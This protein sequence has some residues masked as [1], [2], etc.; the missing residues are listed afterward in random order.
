MRA[1]GE[2]TDRNLNSIRKCDRSAHPL[3]LRDWNQ[4]LRTEFHDSKVAE[5][6]IGRATDTAPVQA[7][8]TVNERQIL[9]QGKHIGGSARRVLASSQTTFSQ[10]TRHLMVQGNKDGLQMQA[11]GLSELPDARCADYWVRKAMHLEEAGNQKEAEGLLLE[12]L[13][14]DVQPVTQ[15]ARALH[16][17]Q[18]RLE[19]ENEALAGMRNEGML[20]H[21]RKSL[22]PSGISGQAVRVPSRLAKTPGSA[23]RNGTAPP[24]TSFKGILKRLEFSVAKSTTTKQ[25]HFPDDGM[26]TAVKST[27]LVG[28]RV[29]FGGTDEM[30]I[31][32]DRGTADQSSNFLPLPPRRRSIH[33]AEQPGVIEED[34]QE[35]SQGGDSDEDLEASGSTGTVNS[36]NAGSTP[37][38]RRLSAL[39]AK[40]RYEDDTDKD[41]TDKDEFA[42]DSGDNSDG[43]GNETEHQNEKFD[44]RECIRQL[45]ELNVNE[46]V[47]DVVNDVAEGE[48][49]FRMISNTNRMVKTLAQL[50]RR[51]LE[52]LNAAKAAEAAENEEKERRMESTFKRS[53]KSERAKGSSPP[54]T[55][56]TA[57]SSL[58]PMSI[59]GVMRDQQS[60]IPLVTPNTVTTQRGSRD[61]S[62]DSVHLVAADLSRSFDTP[63]SNEFSFSFTFAPS[64]RIEHSSARRG[65]S[66]SPSSDRDSATATAAKG[67]ASGEDTPDMLI[68]KRVE[69]SVTKSG[70]GSA[71]RLLYEKSSI[72]SSHRKQTK[73]TKHT[74]DNKEGAQ[75]GPGGVVV[76]SPSK[77]SPRLQRDLGVDKVATPVR[78]SPRLMK[79]LKKGDVA[80]VLE[81]TDYAYSPNPYISGGT[82][83]EGQ[84]QSQS[85]TKSSMHRYNTRSATK[86]R[87][88]SSSQGLKLSPTEQNI[89][90][91]LKESSKQRRKRS[92]TPM[93]EVNL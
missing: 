48:N 16:E 44:T 7:P 86:S 18:K 53:Q 76:L 58:T 51:S 6:V 62:N 55:T 74:I 71:Q 25:L 31:V 1:H 65:K 5:T 23:A 63:P 88:R 69:A 87:R 8:T 54:Q 67:K 64:N 9:S 60:G 56:T 17:L 83:G 3:P 70:L 39:F 29:T 40:Y 4:G 61:L 43:S 19:N 24:P 21:A 90:D 75:G 32:N 92:S 15:V 41:D 49:G 37:F 14:R 47:N 84:S 82:K 28:R 11:Q 73:Q 45:V 12:A 52:D 27:P 57:S 81:A 42:N 35:A 22:T 89:R 66:T 78:R 59:D 46:D 36:R 10:N 38:D 85:E 72:S 79:G 2:N 80:R 26:Y 93:S 33:L 77:A 68:P 91:S 13:Q 30:N 50:L 20:L 34:E